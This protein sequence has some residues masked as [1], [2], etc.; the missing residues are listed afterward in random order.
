MFPLHPRYFIFFLLLPL[1][2]LAQPCPGTISGLKM[3]SYRSTRITISW[4]SSGSAPGYVVRYG[5]SGNITAG[6]S[7]TTTSS[8]V[9]ISGLSP[10]VDY[11]LQVR[12]S[13][14]TSSYGIWSPILTVQTACSPVKAPFTAGFDGPAW[15]PPSFTQSGTINSCWQRAQGQNAVPPP[16]QW[17]AG[18][19]QF[20]GQAGAQDDHSTG[21]A[22][23]YVM[24]EIQ[25]FS[26]GGD[27][28]IFRSPLIDLDT[29]AAPEARFW[30][31]MYGNATGDLKVAVSNDFGATYAPVFSRSGAQQ[32]SSSAPWKEAI[33]NLSA[34]V[35]DTIRLRFVATSNAGSP[36]N[37][38][39]GIDDVTFQA[40]PSCPRPQNVQLISAASTS[41]RLS[42]QSGGAQHW[43]V[44]YGAP[45]LSPAN[46]TIRNT[47]SNPYTLTGLNANSRYE[48]YVRDSCG[49]GDLSVWE[50]PLSART[51]CLPLSAPYT[52]NFDGSNFTPPVSFFGGLGTV[53]PCW[54]RPDTVSYIWEAGPPSF[55]LSGTGP[56][57]DHTPGNTA[58]GYL[59]TANRDFIADDTTRIFSP[60][61]DLSALTLP[62]LRFFLHIYGN[63]FSYFEVAVNNG[64]GY[65]QIYTRNSSI[66][67]NKSAPWQEIILPLGNFTNDT[68][69]LR[70]IGARTGTNRLHTSLD[71]LHIE[72]TPSC[73]KPDSLRSPWVGINATSLQWVSGGASHWQISYG[74]NLNNPAN[75]TLI[76]AGSRPYT[77]SGLSPNTSYHIY[78]R[79]SC[80]PN[81]LSNWEGPLIIQTRCNPLVA[82][83]SQNFDAATTGNFSSLG[84]LPSCWR[85]D[86]TISFAWDVL[87]GTGVNFNSG[88]DEDHSPTGAHYLST[89]GVLQQVDQKRHTTVKM[90]PIDLDTLSRPQIR[91]FYHVYDPN[92]DSLLLI[93]SAPDRAPTVL[94]SQSNTVQ[95][96]PGDPWREDYVDLSAFAGDTVWLE[97]RAVRKNPA[98]SPF[99]VTEIAL[100]DIFIENSPRCRRPRGLSVSNVS[101]TSATID[102]QSGGANNWQLEYGPPGFNPGSG[103]RVS[104]ANKPFQITGLTPGKDYEIV[105]RDSCGSNLLSP[106][107]PPL[108]ITT[109]CAIIPAPFRETFDGPS[110]RAP[111]FS[112]VG[113]LNICWSRSDSSAEYYWVP[114]FSSFDFNT[115]PSSDHTTQAGK[116]IS[117][118]F[119]FNLGANNAAATFNSPPIDLSPLTTPQLRFYEHRYGPD[120]D[121]LIVS[122]NSGNGWTAVLNLTGAN[123]NSKVA[124]WTEQLVSLAAYAGDT[125]QVRFRAVRN[126]LFLPDAIIGIDDFEIRETPS[127]PRPTQLSVSST[128]TT[129]LTLDWTSSASN[130]IIT[131]KE[132]GTNSTQ[133][134]T[135]ASKP[136]TLTGLQPSTSYVINVRDSCGP[137]DISLDSDSLLARTDCGVATAPFTEN[138][139]G[140]LWQEANFTNQFNASIDSCWSTIGADSDFT[141]GQGASGFNSSGPNQDVSGS[142]NYLFTPY[143]FQNNSGE[144]TSP[145]IFIPTTLL[146]PYLKYGYF[147]YGSGISQFDVEI[148]RVGSSGSTIL[149]SYT[150]QTQTSSNAAWRFDSLSLDAYQG[151]T[152]Q[153]IFTNNTSNFS[154][155]AAIDAFQISGTPSPCSSPDSLQVSVV[156]PTELNLS[157]NGQN[158][159][160]LGFTLIYYP[161]NQGTSSADTLTGL[162]SPYSL[163]N[164]SPNTNYQLEL[165]DSCSSGFPSGKAIKTIQTPV[166]PAVSAAFTDSTRFLTAFLNATGAAP[167]DSLIW[168][169]GN[170][171]TSFLPRPQITYTSA[172]TYPVTL[173]VF[174]DCGSTD[175]LTRS[176]QV[177]DTLAAG[178]TYTTQGDTVVLNGSSSQNASSWRWLLGNGRTA[179][180]QFTIARFANTSQSYPV[181]LIVT[182]ACGDR[183]TLTQSVTFCDPPRAE[184][185]FSV[186]PPTGSGLRLQFDATASQNAQFYQWNFGD[187]DTGTGPT[188]IHIYSTPGFFYRVTLIVTNSCDEKDTL[189][190]TLQE[191]SL[192]EAPPLHQVKVYPNPAHQ[193]LHLEWNPGALGLSQIQLINSLGQTLRQRH[194]Q[195][196]G[197]ESLNISSLPS[198]AYWLRLRSSTG[199]W[200]SRAIIIQ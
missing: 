176:I 21:S 110:F 54:R 13:C 103:T 67:P 76:S 47:S 157:W 148:S 168:L 24:A 154:S 160:S 132:S 125:I 3:D 79:D 166:C 195:N 70:F 116:Y 115:G 124:P 97:W 133:R 87:T 19:P 190:L 33:I 98:T 27:S 6:G 119:E 198:G 140:P 68:I 194:P 34:Y 172:G 32:T 77:L 134:I 152:V 184:W 44:S 142:G 4:S 37:Q 12:D 5:P 40:Q 109:S 150:S 113:K 179:N 171:D 151:D 162:S 93:E 8:P 159:N 163:T 22:G 51:N 99:F 147:L 39:I 53:G 85:R 10:N 62:R 111:G 81:D 58:D 114:Q 197:R 145:R 80:G 138:F 189:S 63:N 2:N 64:Q 66:Q 16:M 78:V 173:Q 38:L 17:T 156:S 92:F 90:P 75:G 107:S 73:P 135:T 102:W 43:Q 137:N 105:V 167:T 193:T 174:N 178:F 95:T 180:G 65:Q 146:N 175:S 86:T 61:I 185:T 200:H 55:N 52:E 128:A 50:G 187:G 49:P 45:G 31:H 100:D 60:S 177:C 15:T 29:I 56:L 41:L 26:T 42:W 82:P 69:Q 123:L 94:W 149:S 14:G 182:N 57:N 120:I 183:D 164:L 188:P 127:C 139:D 88:P 96:L 118:A 108:S 129:S 112:S 20:L 130:W 186:L 46:G 126:N 158:S 122:V 155:E 71:D 89:R 91:F 191:V 131:F 35:G 117:T 7:F 165:L 9:T 106:W 28:A 121:S 72:E 104:I 84:S 141:P 25:G 170:G 18:P 192:P 196:T 153:I 36:F 101:T 59:Y 143:S 136:F 161:T 23:Q 1:F 169:L 48:I 83:Y 144:I 30:Y 181:T 74:P 199:T 11:D